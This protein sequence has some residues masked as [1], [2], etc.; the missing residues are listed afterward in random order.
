MICFLRSLNSSV[1]KKQKTT[2]I[3]VFFVTIILNFLASLFYSL[4][5]G[6]TRLVK[7]T[8]ARDYICI[9]TWPVF[10]LPIIVSIMRL[11]YKSYG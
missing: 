3:R 9:W 2:I 7:T 11:H 1:L 4:A 10:D 6:A 5:L 8:F